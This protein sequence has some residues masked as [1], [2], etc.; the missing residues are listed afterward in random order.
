VATYRTETTHVDPISRDYVTLAFGIERHVP[1]FVDAYFGQEE[2]KEAALAGEPAAP[3]D[4]LGQAND[5][6]QR[7][8]GG[9]YPEQRKGYLTVQVRGMIATCRKIA[10]DPL[11]Y[12]D[13]VRESFDIEPD[14][15]PETLFDEA[16]AE[17]DAL[18]PGT[19]DV[20]ERMTAWRKHYEISPEV[21]RT[22]IALISDEAR[23][24][25]LAFVDLPAGESIEYK[26]VQ[27]EPWGGYNWYFGN[28]KSRV[29]IN[30]DLPIRVLDLPGL[31]THEAYPGHHTEHALK[32]II[33][34]RDHGYGEHAIQLIN[35]P[36]CVISE[37]IATL[38]DSVIFESEELASWLAST[39]YPAAGIAGDPKREAA[40][41][42]AQRNLRAVGANAAL[43]LHDQGASEAEAVS[44]LM[45]Y[46]LRS[47]DEA[48]KNL[49]FI[50]DPLWRTY[51]FCYHAGRDLLGEWLNGA[52]GDERKSRFRTLLT[53]QVYPSQVRGWIEAEQ[54]PN[55]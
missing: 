18:L 24:R 51:I 53:E 23:R 35:T 36:E 13:E 4:L 54:T 50:T 17:L 27:N 34:Y 44:Y 5:L 26:M 22:L 10:G 25:T 40:I 45:R 48:R 43:L 30:T 31:I 20:N 3:V 37:G 7:V 38:S 11:P 52:P 12:R 49:S 46:S 42:R 39:V 19:G 29:D 32:E 6:L 8:N 2:V 21:A 41:G 16:I 9:S 15:T 47:E 33:L 1:G 14:S 28:A 55:A